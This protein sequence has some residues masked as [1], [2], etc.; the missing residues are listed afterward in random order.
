M[1]KSRTFVECVSNVSRTSLEQHVHFLGLKIVQGSPKSAIG[2]IIQIGK[3][4]GFPYFNERLYVVC[5]D[6]TK[7][8]F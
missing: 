4:F 3:F 6:G 1:L 5:N 2:Y 8:S 7:L